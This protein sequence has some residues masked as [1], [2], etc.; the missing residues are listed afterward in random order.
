MRRWVQ[1][2][3]RHLLRTTC[4]DTRLESPRELQEAVDA[5]VATTAARRAFVRPS[6]T[7]DVVR[8][9]AEAAT[10]HDADALALKVLQAVHRL[11]GGVGEMPMSV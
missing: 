9:F 1:V 3:D 8:V 6:G 11:A 2:S 10:Q 7:Q 5:A 4:M